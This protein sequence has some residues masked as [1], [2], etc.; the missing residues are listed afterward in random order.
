ML[1]RPVVLVVVD[2]RHGMPAADAALR[3]RQLT[4]STAA[5]IFVTSDALLALSLRREG[6]AAI[7]DVDDLDRDGV[8]ARDRLA[9]EAV[10][11]AFIN[12]SGDQSMIGSVRYAPLFTY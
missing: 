10:E 3:R 2:D 4:D 9:T 5:L 7:L 12:A 1:T 6:R 11:A 8:L